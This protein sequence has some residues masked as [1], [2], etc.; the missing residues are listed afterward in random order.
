MYLTEAT[1]SELRSWL[2]IHEDYCQVFLQAMK[3]LSPSGTKLTY[4][5]RDGRPTVDIALPANFKPWN[6]ASLGRNKK[7]YVAVT[8]NS[9]R[10]LVIRE[11][12]P[13]EGVAKMAANDVV[14]SLDYLKTV[15]EE[16]FNAPSKQR[17]WPSLGRR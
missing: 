2:G 9:M 15:L 14:V 5:R 1:A 16:A 17:R 11:S 6:F 3:E 8:L 4:R 13:S 10:A 12:L 7:G